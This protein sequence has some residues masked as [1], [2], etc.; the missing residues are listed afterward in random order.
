MKY[1]IKYGI[2]NGNADEDFIMTGLMT[3]F[4]DLGRL[5]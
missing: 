1:K 5:P 2:F 4:T 3:D